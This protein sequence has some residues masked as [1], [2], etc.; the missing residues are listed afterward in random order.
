MVMTVGVLGF[1]V[2]GAS[3]LFQTVYV[4]FWRTT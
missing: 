1:L 3:V 4:K 2:V